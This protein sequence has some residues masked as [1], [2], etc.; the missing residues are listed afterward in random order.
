MRSHLKRKGVIDGKR[1]SLGDK[2]QPSEQRGLA[3]VVETATK[4]ESLGW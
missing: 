1:F 4:G 2:T 3:H